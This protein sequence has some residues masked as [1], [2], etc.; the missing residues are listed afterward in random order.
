MI[1]IGTTFNYDIAL[2]DQLPMI[3]GAGFSHISLGANIGHADYLSGTARRNIKAMVMDHGLAICSLHVPFGKDLDISSPDNNISDRTVETYQRCVEAAHQLGA[4]V[5]IFHPTRHMRFDNL[6]QR[7]RAITRNI[8]KMLNSAG[9]EGVKLAIEN[10]RFDPSNDV[11]V[12]SLDEITDARYGLCYDSS[13][14]NLVAKTHALLEKCGSRLLATHISDNRGKEDDHLLPFEGCY[15]W[16]C[17]YTLFSRI[18]FQGVFLLEVEMR[19]S[20]FKEP[21]VFLRE[22]F[23]RGERI[24]HSC[25][26]A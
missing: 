5:V 12:H 14:D 9:V 7:K 11:L 15:D 26:K 17:F 4:G 24:L 20:M 25:G 23:E 10:D 18:P 2:K 22:A 3:K 13:H 21:E 8:E 16:P 1:S 6:E 19:A